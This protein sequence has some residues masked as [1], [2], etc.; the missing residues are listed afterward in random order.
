[1]RGIHKSPI[2]VELEIS[3]LGVRTRAHE[4]T[5]T[6]SLSGTRV[7][8]AFVF[9]AVLRSDFSLPKAGP[10]TVAVTTKGLYAN[11]QR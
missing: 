11:V 7:A 1:M 4:F 8:R 9:V 6:K 3:K 10:A 2:V 5:C